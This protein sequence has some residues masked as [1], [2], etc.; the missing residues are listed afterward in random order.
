MQHNT[1]PEELSNPLEKYTARIQTHGKYRFSD[2]VLRDFL[3]GG[4]DPCVMP[5]CESRLC[6]MEG[7]DANHLL[8]EKESRGSISV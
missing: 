4:T 5:V 8:R 7:W 1:N 3:N 2:Q 6:T